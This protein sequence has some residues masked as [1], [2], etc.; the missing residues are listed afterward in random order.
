MHSTTAA[1]W[2]WLCQPG[3]FGQAV[4]KQVR[5]PTCN[6]AACT[7]TAPLTG[8]RPH[9]PRLA[10]AGP[11][12]WPAQSRLAC[13]AWA[14]RRCCCCY[15]S[16]ARPAGRKRRGLQ[17]V[18]LDS[19]DFTCPRS[20]MLSPC[21]HST[22]T[23]SAAPPAGKCCQA[24]HPGAPRRACADAPRRTPSAHSKAKMMRHADRVRPVQGPIS[25]AK[26]PSNPAASKLPSTI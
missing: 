6:A 4:Q 26:A 24:S 15:H 9:P 5:H 2:A 3:V 11:A 8:S 13:S 18:E 20:N 1:G 25:A 14:T 19:L 21:W 23:A 16:R 22:T 10:C 17:G 12:A 7:H